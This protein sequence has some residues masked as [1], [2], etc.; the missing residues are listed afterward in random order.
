M[1][2]PY[3]KGLG[4]L[5]QYSHLYALDGGRN[6]ILDLEAPSTHSR[7]VGKITLLLVVFGFAYFPA[8]II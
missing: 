3:Q 2:G 4:T 6:M 1:L 7:P 5:A 8:V